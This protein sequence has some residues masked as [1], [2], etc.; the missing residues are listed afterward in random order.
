MKKSSERGKPF[1]MIHHVGVVV[2]DIDKAIEY[3]ESLGIGPFKF[4]TLSGEI[5]EQT[6]Y[7]KPDEFVL[8][9]AVADIG[10]IEV[11]LIQP[12]DNAPVQEKFLES[13][14]EGINHLGFKVEDVEEEESGLLKKGFN[15]IQGRKRTSGVVTGYFDTDRVGG[16]IVELWQPP[17][18]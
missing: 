1:S 12:V 18:E 17:N 16:V 4:M 11:E 3:Y 5:T 6:L 10:E 7:G 9:G 8:K 14:G 13:R 15:N 2:R